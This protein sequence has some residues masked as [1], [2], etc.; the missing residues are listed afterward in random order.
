VPVVISD[1]NPRARALVSALRS[2]RQQY[3]ITSRDLSRRMGFS[4]AFVSH[5]ETG[6]R[7]PS[8]D[9]VAALLGELRVTGPER[10][11]IMRLATDAAESGW[12]GVVGLPGHI[13]K[14]LDCERWADEVVEWAP[15]LIP[16]LLQTPEYARATFDGASH[17]EAE[18]RALLRGGRRE[19]VD[20]GIAPV[21]FAALISETAL[22]EPIGSARVMVD[23]L[24]QL[25]ESA[26]R[27]NI[28][29]QIVPTLIGWHPG[30]AGAF[31]MYHFAE[32]PEILYFPHYGSGVFCT[33]SDHVLQHH[34]ALDTLRDKA[35]SESRSIKRIIDIARKWAGAV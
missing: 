4:H 13:V 26:Q 20:H 10:D 14:A 19:V 23:Q 16:E 25:A 1:L 21:R 31:T 34:R 29:I 18:S 6:R 28:S 8:P 5:W 2:I 32:S 11:R 9:E 35:L 7:V 24:G 33:E 15:A 27:P 22:R 3:G 17:V 30:L 12:P